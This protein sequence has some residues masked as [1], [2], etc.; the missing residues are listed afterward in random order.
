MLNLSKAKKLKPSDKDLP[1]GMGIIARSNNDTTISLILRKK[2]KGNKSPVSLLLGKYPIDK[3][4][5]MVSKAIQYSK[6]CTEGIHPKKWEEEQERIEAEKE[7]KKKSKE[8]TLG[9][10]LEQY[11]KDKLGLEQNVKATIKDRNNCIKSICGDWLD[12][13][14][15]KIDY[16]MIFNRFQEWSSQRGSKGRAR[17][18]GTYCQALWEYAFRRRYLQGGNIFK[19]LKDEVGG[20]SSTQETYNYLLPEECSVLYDRAIKYSNA[21]WEGLTE[22]TSHF[23]NYTEQRMAMVL[24]LLTGLRLNEVL[25]LKWEQVFIHKDTLPT[26]FKSK[27][28][29]HYNIID[30]DAIPHIFFPKGTRK[31]KK[32]MLAIPIV[33]AMNQVF[34]FMSR[35][36]KYYCINEKGKKFDWEAKLQYDLSRLKDRSEENIEAYKRKREK[37]YEE[38]KKGINEYVFPSHKVIGSNI[39]DIDNALLECTPPTLNTKANNVGVGN[40]KRVEKLTAKTL[41]RTFSQIGLYL[42]FDINTLEFITG[43][44]ATLKTTSAFG[45][46]VSNTLQNAIEPYEKIIM[47]ILNQS[48]YLE[49]IMLANL[50][51][52]EKERRDKQ[53]QQTDKE[54][55][56]YFDDFMKS[57]FNDMAEYQKH[58]NEKNKNL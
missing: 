44:T 48:N 1:L 3:E 38:I 11:N 50:S 6:L 56:K 25:K 20:F 28:L 15:T 46:Y 8:R 24:L 27:E 49:D 34:Y 23:T 32:I 29:E 5:D 26:H 9:V 35:Y 31:Q 51:D 21:E 16:E 13:P 19:Q 37:E 57:G 40:I 47:A 45:S 43:R 41:R 4:E 30:K 33:N 14:I 17:V 58:L 7:K 53:H 22:R 52:E 10:I 36:R 42:K 54:M 18:W 39:S 55:N 12:T 2:I